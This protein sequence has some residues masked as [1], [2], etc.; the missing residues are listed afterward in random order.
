MVCINY[1]LNYQVK[2]ASVLD[3]AFFLL[4][5]ETPGLHFFFCSGALSNFV[6]NSVKVVIVVYWS[7]FYC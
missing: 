1:T 3:V 7:N 2:I 6:D 4:I 5:R